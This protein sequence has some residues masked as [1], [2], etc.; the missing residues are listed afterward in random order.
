MNDDFSLARAT[1]LGK[2]GAASARPPAGTALKVAT[3]AGAIAL[4]G[5][6]GAT[7]RE[8]APNAPRALTRDL[9]IEPG[10]PP[11]DLATPADIALL[12]GIRQRA[13]SR[14]ESAALLPATSQSHPDLWQRLRA[15]MS[16][17][18]IENERIAQEI[19]WY[20]THPQYLRRVTDRA[21]L[22]LAFI[23]AEAEARGLPTELALLPIVESAF[24]PYARSP[25]GAIGIWQFIPATGQRFGLRRSHWYD[26]R[27]DILDS[28]RAA[29]D[30]LSYLHQS[31]GHDWLLAIAGYNAGEGNV[32]RAL[33]HTRA[34]SSPSDFFSLDLPAETEAYVPRLL[35]V[36][37][38]VAEPER[39]GVTLDPIDQSPYFEVVDT[40][41][42]IDLSKAA[43]MAGVPL[44]EL[45]LLNPGFMRHAT[46]PEGPHRL[47]LPSEAVDLFK[48][49]LQAAPGELKPAFAR[50][51]VRRG[52]TLTSIAKRYA[53]TVAEIR[54][55]NDLDAGKLAVGRSIDIPPGLDSV[56]MAGL[57]AEV[58]EGMRRARGDE[59]RT[60]Y[61]VRRGDSLW[62]IARRHGTTVAKV[63][64]WNRL[65]QGHLLRPG[66]RLVL[67]VARRGRQAPAQVSAY[68]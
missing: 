24:Q 34:S 2:L 21:R 18:R 11:A 56:A 6:N 27:R 31:L 1:R 15:G 66:Q 38:L 26:G 23:V 35:A 17:E 36:S 47:V 9:L 64:R 33:R 65:R 62:L 49:S 43:Q 52:D 16:I 29:F 55:N 41:S 12:A 5:C 51:V 59:T 25:A 48:D 19:E 32:R 63:R 22:Y 7:V 39:Y 30:Y 37:A 50:H 10:P 57:S 40:P 53:T 28:T 45:M 42:Q 8:D 60:V 46:D 3:L 58:R 14:V 4:T 20:R 67:W 68:R 13:E 54:A 44:N 61:R